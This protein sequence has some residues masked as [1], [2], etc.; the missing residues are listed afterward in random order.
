MKNVIAI[1]AVVA[2]A[3]AFSTATLAQAPK[4]AAPA[5]A[6]PATPATPPAGDAT[7][8]TPATPATAAAPDKGATAKKGGTKGKK[9]GA[10]KGHQTGGKSK[11]KAPKTDTKS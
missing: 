10:T 9:K 1:A 5:K 7:K 8:A 3:L 4:G 11:S 2:S 6:T